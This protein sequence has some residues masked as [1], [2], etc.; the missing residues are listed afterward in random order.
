MN[1]FLE[2]VKCFDK[3]IELDTKF[4]DAINNKG[5]CLY[6]LGN[7]EKAIECFRKIFEYNPN[8]YHAKNGM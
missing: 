3:A 6:L 8:F 1:N 2:A 4:I 7:H 5:N